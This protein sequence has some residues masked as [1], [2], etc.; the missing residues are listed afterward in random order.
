VLGADYWTFDDGEWYSSVRNAILL[1]VV[2]FDCLLVCNVLKL[3]FDVC[4]FVFDLFVRWFSIRSFV[5]SF[6]FF[7]FVSCLFACCLFLVC[8]LVVCLLVVQLFV[9]LLF[10]CLITKLWVRSQSASYLEKTPPKL[11]SSQG[12]M[13]IFS[14]YISYE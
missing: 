2:L 3:K 10:V 6:I 14:L 5:R 11:I 4:S 9:C 7:F 12:M 1:F 8:L 13:G